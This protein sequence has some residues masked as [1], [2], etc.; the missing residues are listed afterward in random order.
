MEAGEGGGGGGKRYSAALHPQQFQKGAV[1]ATNVAQVLRAAPLF[2]VQHIEAVRAHAGLLLILSRSRQ[3]EHLSKLPEVLKH[4][5][6][7]A[8]AN[9]NAN[10]NANANA[11]ANANP[12]PN[13]NPN[14]N[15][16]DHS[17]S[18]TEGQQQ[19]QRQRQRGIGMA[20]D[21][22]SDS[23]SVNGNGL[24]LTL[25]PEEWAVVKEVEH[26]AEE[27]DQLAERARS[28]VECLVWLERQVQDQ[29]S[30]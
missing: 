25:V 24:T 29:V 15:G 3:L 5:N 27:A 12:N 18:E 21:S 10:P 26:L 6:A 7:N 11:N 20:M 17:E 4:A 14:A 8:N 9:P 28:A 19:Q 1:A 22:N 23:D 30:G 13:P 16:G 2:S